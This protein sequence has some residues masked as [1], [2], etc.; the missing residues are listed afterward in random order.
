[1]SHCC[2][3]RTFHFSGSTG[4]IRSEISNEI[5]LKK[6]YKVYKGKGVLSGGTSSD[7][8]SSI[9]VNSKYPLVS[10]IS[11]IAPSPDWFIGVHDLDLCNTTTGEWVDSIVRNLFPYDAGTDSGEE[12]ESLNK[13]SNPQQEIHLLTNMI[14]GSFKGDQPVK[15]FGTFTFE[16]I[17]DGEDKTTK[18]PIGTA[19]L[20]TNVNTTFILI[21]C[22]L[23]TIGYII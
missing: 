3:S 21:L 17:S 1:M 7:S 19:N 10:F 5:T 20:N 18:A 2:L 8:I 6:A 14:N 16:K 15:S 9:E 11:M 22:I 13:I 4:T 23:N 12:F